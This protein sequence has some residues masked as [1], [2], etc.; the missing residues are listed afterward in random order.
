MVP[1]RDSCRSR[2]EEGAVPKRGIP[3]CPPI[4][5]PARAMVSGQTSPPQTTSSCG[6][7]SRKSGL[8]WTPG[9]LEGWAGPPQ[10]VQLQLRPPRPALTP[11]CSEMCKGRIQTQ[12]ESLGPAVP[13]SGPLLRVPGTLA[14]PLGPGL[15]LL[16]RSRGACCSPFCPAPCTRAPRTQASC[17][18][19]PCP[20]DSTCGHRGLPSPRPRG[21]QL[22]AP[23]LPP[24]QA[25][26]S[27][28]SHPELLTVGAQGEGARHRMADDKGSESLRDLTVRSWLCSS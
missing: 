11:S 9:T 3:S 20:T 21:P 18:S 5:A 17:W 25:A 24:T 15:V 6:G 16:S 19:V 8:G 4:P 1:P 26:W 10:M 2:G 23:H 22:P 12:A 14:E 27:F 13:L 28:L 7:H